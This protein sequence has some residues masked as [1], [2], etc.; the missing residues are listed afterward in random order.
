[1]GKKR[2]S[3]DSVSIPTKKVKLSNEEESERS[4]TARFDCQRINS[5]SN[6]FNAHLKL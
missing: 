4:K 1:M 2:K 5:T 6:L 3:S